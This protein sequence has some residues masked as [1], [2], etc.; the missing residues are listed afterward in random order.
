MNLLPS[1]N[2]KTSILY[3]MYYIEILW[4]SGLADRGFAVADYTC[5][6][7]S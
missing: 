5:E 2:D 1:L 3:A 6:N 7:G 4:T